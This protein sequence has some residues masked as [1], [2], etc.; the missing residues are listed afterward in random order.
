MP[1]KRY[2]FPL[3]VLIL[4]ISGY[5]WLPDHLEEGHSRL[6]VPVLPIM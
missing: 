4:A 3:V 1:E 5:N 2:K 6:Q